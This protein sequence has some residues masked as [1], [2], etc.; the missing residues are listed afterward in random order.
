MISP[1]RDVEE[2]C[3]LQLADN[4]LVSLNAECALR[5]CVNS[6]WTWG[7]IEMNETVANS[8]CGGTMQVWF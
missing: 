8:D 3:F 1:L 4:I 6:A 5:P 2:N 7:R